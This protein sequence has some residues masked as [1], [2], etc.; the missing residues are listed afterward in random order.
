MAKI[1]YREILYGWD[2]DNLGVRPSLDAVSMDGLRKRFTREGGKR[3]GVVVK[4]RR[5]RVCPGVHALSIVNHSMAEHRPSRDLATPNALLLRA[6]K[7]W[8]P[9]AGPAFTHWAGGWESQDGQRFVLVQRVAA[10][11]VLLLPWLMAYTR[12]RGTRQR[13]AVPLTNLRRRLSSNGCRWN[14]ATCRR[15]ENAHTHPPRRSTLSR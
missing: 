12:R 5:L 15:G 14:V 13:D 8:R 3:A 2:P 6:V 10:V 9:H 4:G 11:V 1:N 7:L